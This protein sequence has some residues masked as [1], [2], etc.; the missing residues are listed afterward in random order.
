MTGPSGGGAPPLGRDPDPDPFP[1]LA[2][3][4]ADAAKIG[5]LALAT[6]LATSTSDGQPSVRMVL[7]KEA[8]PEG[9]VFYSDSSSRKGSELSANP[10]AALCLHWPALSRQLRVEGTVLELDPAASDRYF[11]SRPRG[12]QLAAVVSHQSQIVAGRSVLER[13]M[14]ELA[15]RLEAAPVPRPERWLG[16]RVVPSVIEFWCQRD[17]RLHDRWQYHRGQNGWSRQR[18]QP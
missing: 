14:E 4:I 5:P 9:L 15:A 2:S 16:Y 11:A 13:G 18:L 17:N 7:L 3:W 12:S 6:A 8:G 10:R 1:L